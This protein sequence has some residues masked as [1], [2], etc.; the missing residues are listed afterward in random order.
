MDALFL[1]SVEVMYPPGSEVR[2]LPGAAALLW[3]GAVRP[4][5]FE[6][7]L[8]VVAK[9]FHLVRPQV[10][11]FGQKDIQQA[12]LVRQMVRDLDFPVEVVVSPTVREPDGLAL[13]SRNAYL[14]AGERREAL[15]L[16]QSLGAADQVWR[17]G[18]RRAE[19]IMAVI[20]GGTQDVSRCDSGLYCHH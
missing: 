3:E 16:S 8:T 10:A 6:G 5:H 9:L 19:A 18:E 1:P 13:S 20:G 4:G 15:G 17:A 2:V 11:V 7:V 12:V 14:S